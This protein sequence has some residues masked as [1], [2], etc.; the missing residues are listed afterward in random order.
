MEIIFFIQIYHSSD[1]TAF[2]SVSTYLDT[3]SSGCPL[4]NPR[5]PESEIFPPAAQHT[6]LILQSVSSNTMINGCYPISVANSWPGTFRW[7]TMP[8]TLGPP[9]LSRTVAVSQDKCGSYGSTFYLK[10][11]TRITHY[12]S[13]VENNVWE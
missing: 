9:A 12:Y 13:Q 2:R 5:H 4:S 7:K 11:A 6:P 1:G 3:N 8:P 10:S